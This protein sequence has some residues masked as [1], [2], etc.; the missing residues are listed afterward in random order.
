MIPEIMLSRPEDSQPSSSPSRPEDEGT[1]RAR[2]ATGAHKA[3]PAGFSVDWGL[4][5]H[6]SKTV[7]TR[8]EGIKQSA[9]MQK[10]GEASQKF[11]AIV[12]HVYTRFNVD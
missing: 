3:A 8:H 10:G 6:V 9:I 2:P 4:S 12:N 11:G 1:H 7:T 5:P